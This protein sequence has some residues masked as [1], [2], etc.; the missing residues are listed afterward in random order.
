[1]KLSKRTLQIL[2]N[3]SAINQSVVFFPGNIIKTVVP[4]NT[5]DFFS[6]ATVEET[7]TVECAI[8]DIRRFLNCLDLFDDPEIE[9]DVNFATISDGKNTLRYVYVDKDIIDSPDYS[10]SPKVKT[11]LAEFK[12]AGEHIKTAIKASSLLGIN[13][14]ELVGDADGNVRL[15]AADTEAESDNFSLLIEEDVD[16]N[17]EFK[18]KYSIDKLRLLIEDDYTVRLS[19]SVLTEFVGDAG[20]VYHHG[21]LIETA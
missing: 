18:S 2:K 6:A 21:G 13:D 9:F 7:F 11:L 5:Q 17:G 19:T 20:V 12:L 15:I 3:F 1:M 4:G 10:R 8:Y 14:V 16:Y